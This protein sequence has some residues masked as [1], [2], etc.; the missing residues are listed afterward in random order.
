MGSFI[1]LEATFFHKNALRKVNEFVNMCF[2]Q[3]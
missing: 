1:E 3:K 2:F